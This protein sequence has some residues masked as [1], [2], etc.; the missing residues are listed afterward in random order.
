MKASGRSA[1]LP[2]LLPDE[3]KTLRS[4]GVRVIRWLLFRPICS[5]PVGFVVNG[6]VADC[7][8]GRLVYIGLRNVVAGVRYTRVTAKSPGN[9]LKNQ[10]TLS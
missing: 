9:E 3:W 5:N 7:V 4:C 8:G 10:D 2:E 6:N 1:G